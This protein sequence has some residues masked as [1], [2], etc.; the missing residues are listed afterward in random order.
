MELEV[1]ENREDLHKAIYRCDQCPKAG[2]SMKRVQP[3]WDPSRGRS[4]M[5]KWGLLIGQAPGITEFERSNKPQG[6]TNRNSSGNGSPGRPIAFSGEAG[7]RL[8][9]WIIEDAGFNQ[10]QT[11]SLFAK[12]SVV[13]CYPGRPSKTKTDRKPTRKEI[14][15]CS[16]FLYEQIRLYD[17]AVIIPMGTVAVKWF[18]PEVAKLAEAVGEELNW[19][20]GDKQFPVVCLPHSSNA[21]NWWKV[22][23]SL[24]K[25]ALGHIAALRSQAAF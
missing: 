5:K 19:Q 3:P 25:K 10:A 4:S 18:F 11:H 22:N 23:E 6:T 9:R 14:K 16:P 13:K 24:R 1:Y 2:F 20:Y 21:S 17:P 8:E 12:T 7:R 15:F